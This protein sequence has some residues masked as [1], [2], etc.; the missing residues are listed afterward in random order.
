MLANLTPQQILQFLGPA[1]IVAAILV[2]F[3]VLLQ[4]PNAVGMGG[5]FG[6]SSGGGGYRRRRGL[7]STLLRFTVFMMVMFAVFSFVVAILEK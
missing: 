1:Q 5:T 2:G 3:G 7:E 4:T 6:S